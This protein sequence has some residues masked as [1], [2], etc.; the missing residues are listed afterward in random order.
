MAGV[1]DVA[2]LDVLNQGTGVVDVAGGGGHVS[3]ALSLSGVKSTVVDPRDSCGM[4]PKRDRKSYRRALRKSNEGSSNCFI[5]QYDTHRAWFGGRIDGADS[6]FSGG[7]DDP[8]TIPSCGTTQDQGTSKTLM[9]G[10]SLIVAMH[11]DEAT[12]SAIDWAVAHR[13]PFF[14][15]PCCVFGRLFPNR[16]LAT[17]AKVDTAED[18]VLYLMEKHPDTKLGTLDMDGANQCIYYTGKT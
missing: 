8:N 11:P 13:R 17:G 15:V 1:L 18:F 10:C 4:L 16:R 2:Y 12:E 5:L 3:M 14:I 7:A 9:D 6:A